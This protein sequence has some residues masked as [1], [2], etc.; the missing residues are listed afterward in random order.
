MPK[1]QRTIQATETAMAVDHAPRNHV[2]RR[3][4][5]ALILAAMVS[6]LFA[7]LPVGVNAQGAPESVSWSVG[8]A[9]GDPNYRYE[10]T[11]GDTVTDEF[12]IAN[13]SSVNLVLGVYASDAFTTESGDTDLL[14][15]G[16]PSNG[17][18]SWVYPSENTVTVNAGEEVAVPF[19]IVVPASATAGDHVGGI[20][21]SLV[22]SEPDADGEQ[23]TI[24]RRLGSRIYVRVS[25]QAA[26]SVEFTN[27]ELNY[28]QTWNP[29]G[30]GTLTA[31]YTLNNTG[32]MVIQGGG[33]ATATPSLGGEATAQL[34][35]IDE[36]LPGNSVTRSVAISNVFPGFGTEVAVQFFPTV[37]TPAGDDD[38]T[39]EPLL[40]TA[41]TSLFPLPQ[42]IALLVLIAI[43]VMVVVWL[44]ARNNGTT[45]ASSI[46]ATSPT[47]TS[48]AQTPS[49][50]P[51][52][53]VVTTPA[54]VSSPHGEPGEPATAESAVVDRPTEGLWTTPDSP[55]P[56]PPVSPFSN[57]NGQDLESPTPIFTGLPENTPED[58]AI[59]T[60]NPVKND[61][62]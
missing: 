36:L 60:N 46:T 28:D 17:V 19:E 41:D 45:P 15:A 31:T 44:R 55:P 61:E 49:A 5:V 20:V 24:E 12:L 38:L 2:A 42:I 40:A 4:T 7:V 54:P 33:Q 43:I 14:Q 26:P 57:P 27:L 47:T 35:E 10:V 59:S 50:A 16:E 37:E 21:T 1:P 29:F 8:T 18:G 6:A 32:N 23:V 3:G 53:Q 56:V 9:A 30:G 58:N 39:V 34:D 25:G 13:H 51:T 22:L 62:S 52:A 48:A 11:A